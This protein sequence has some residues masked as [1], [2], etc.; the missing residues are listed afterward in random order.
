MQKSMAGSLHLSYFLHNHF[1]H[2]NFVIFC[3][4]TRPVSYWA[5]AREK[6]HSSACYFPHTESLYIFYVLSLN[7]SLI[8][9]I[10]IS[11][12]LSGRIFS[13]KILMCDGWEDSR[14]VFGFVGPFLYCACSHKVF[15]VVLLL[16]SVL[17][18]R[19]LLASKVAGVCFQLLPSL[20]CL[21]F[22]L[23]T[24]VLLLVPL[25]GALST[26]SLNKQKHIYDSA[27][28]T[29]KTH[30]HLLQIIERVACRF[31]LCLL[32]PTD[33]FFFFW[34]VQPVGSETRAFFTSNRIRTFSL[35]LKS[36][37]PT[38]QHAAPI[39]CARDRPLSTWWHDSFCW[40]I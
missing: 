35:T 5:R 15:H 29:E 24:S 1:G 30:Q 27:C 17:I 22:G 2:F 7:F 31:V 39:S 26:G 6:Q 18:V 14:L 21:S 13:G 25:L 33:G 28:Q 20:C 34:Q 23:Q 40:D 11:T 19:L 8:R 10:F 9:A 4:S 38:Q 16:F 36:P 12:W 3:S 32:L 37:V